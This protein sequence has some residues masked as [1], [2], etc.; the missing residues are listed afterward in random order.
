MKKSTIVFIE[1]GMLAGIIVAGIMLP[2]STSLSAFLLASGACFVVGNFLIF[3]KIKRVRTGEITAK[4][5]P[6][7]HL[8]RAFAILAVAWILLWLLSRK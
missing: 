7:P 4:D 5:G 2:K 3:R 1:F 8:F 6:W